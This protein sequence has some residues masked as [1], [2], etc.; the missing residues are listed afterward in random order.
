MG[1]A[2]VG[3]WAGAFVVWGRAG[4]ADASSE[5]GGADQE[6]KQKID[7]LKASVVGKNDE[8]QGKKVFAPQNRPEEGAW[9]YTPR[10]VCMQG[11]ANFP[12]EYR[13]VDCSDEKYSSPYNWR[14]VRGMQH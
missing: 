14:E 7:S 6:V 13:D 9:D 3:L 8:T 2:V 11:K 4:V 5:R 10:E 12:E 1:V